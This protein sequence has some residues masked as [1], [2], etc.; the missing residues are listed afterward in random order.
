[1]RQAASQQFADFSMLA[2][3]MFVQCVVDLILEL[4]YRNEITQLTPWA[5]AIC[6]GM[7]VL[8]VFAAERSAQRIESGPAAPPDPS[9]NVISLLPTVSAIAVYAVMLWL[10]Q[11]G[12]RAPLGVLVSA[13]VAL[14][15]LFLA[16]QTLTVRE[17]AALLLARTEADSRAR[18]EA[19]AREGQ[20]LEAVGRLAGGIAHDFNNLLTTVLGNADFALTQLRPGDRAHDEVRDIRSAAVR[21][22][23]LIRQL[24]AFSRKSVV[25]PVRLQPDVVLREMERLLQRLAGD[26]CGILLEL[27]ADV[28]LVQVDRGQLEQALANLVTNARDA[29]PDGGAIVVSARNVALDVPCAATLTLPAGDYVTIAVQDSGIG[30]AADVRNQIFEPF[31]STKARGKGTGLGLASTYGI[32]RQSHGAIGVQSAEGAGSCFTLYLPR[33]RATAASVGADAPSSHDQAP[34]GRGETILLVEDEMMVRQVARRMLEAEGYSVLTAPDAVSARSI[35]ERQ[36]ATIALM[37]TDVMMPGESG[38]ELAA[39]LRQQRPELAVIFISGYSDTEL[40]DRD[41]RPG[42]DDF[43]QKPFTSSQLLSRVDARLRGAN[44]PS[45]IDAHSR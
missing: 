24:L 21:G 2:I 32:M 41:G 7:Y 42:A 1:M 4:D 26:R 19:L 3:A 6:P 27:A 15:I 29:M 14:N 33:V 17:N 9:L 28:G 20:K 38:I 45:P 44:R 22:A 8:I 13:A 37:V 25:A 23:D 43:V 5:A 39:F 18:Y 40:P 34:L 16:K 31:F 36:G 30:I 35:F 12:H 10:A 11:S